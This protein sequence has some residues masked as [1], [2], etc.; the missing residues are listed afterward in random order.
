MNR[1]N[2]DISIK[3]DNLGKIIEKLKPF[4]F[5]LLELQYTIN[6]RPIKS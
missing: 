2:S 3:N 1:K 5:P 6:N 4:A